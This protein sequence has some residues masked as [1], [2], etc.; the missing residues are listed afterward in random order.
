M[1]VANLQEVPAQPVNQEGTRSA[2]AGFVVVSDLR[3]VRGRTGNKRMIV[4]HRTFFGQILDL[5]GNLLLLPLRAGG[6]LITE[7]AVFPLRNLGQKIPL[8]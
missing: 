3:E 6:A 1:I 2:F 4:L 7:L 5:S 8:A